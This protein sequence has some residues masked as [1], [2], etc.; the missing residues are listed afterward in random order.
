MSRL[1]QIALTLLPHI[2]PATAKAMLSYCGSPEAIFSTSKSHLLKIPSIGPKTA[3]ALR[4]DAATFARAEEELQFIEKEGIEM[5][6][7]TDEAYPRRLRNCIDSPVLLYKKGT[8]DLHTQR[9]ISVVGTRNCTDYGREFCDNLIADLAAADVIVVSGLAFGIDVAAH[10][11][12]IKHK[13]PTVG[14]IAHGLD[15]LYPKEHH[16][17]ARKMLEHG[18]AL[19]T[20]FT[21]RTRPDRENFPQRN[22]IIAGLADATLVVEAGKKGGALITA[23]IARSYNREVFAVPGRVGDT[24]SEG[25]LDLIR[26]NKAALITS[27]ADLMREMGWESNALPA[28]STNQQMTLMLDLADDEMRIMQA[29]DKPLPAT[30]DELAIG[31]GMNTGQLASAL[32][33]LEMQGLIL[34]LPGKMYRKRR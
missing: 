22:R 13:V 33:N 18:G 9:I 14:V 1:H 28:E 6:F 3:D 21:S 17:T 7:Y 5:I 29:L 26:L 27:A 24:A 2:G 30:V 34:S 31:T 19:L 4:N 23:D 12:C 8:T 20:D 32:L 10:K 25:C 11:A 16:S 15:T